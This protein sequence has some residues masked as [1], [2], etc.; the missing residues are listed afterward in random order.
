MKTIMIKDI[1]GSEVRSRSSIKHI[2]KAMDGNENTFIVD[3]N[4]VDFISRSSADELYNLTLDV[5]E[6]HIINTIDTVKKMIDVVWDGRKAKRI[7]NKEN[8]EIEDYS[9]VEDFLDFLKT[10]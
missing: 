5:K 3:M 1:I 4:G 6:M 2:R 10:I 8:I 9:K 7:R